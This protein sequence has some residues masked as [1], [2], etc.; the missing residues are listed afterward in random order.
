VALLQAAHEATIDG[1]LVVS[2]DG[3]VITSN[4]RFRE[5]W[6]IPDEVVARRSDEEALAS[7]LHQLEDPDGFLRRV[8]ELYTARAAGRDEVR[9]LDGRVFDRYGSP[10]LGADG[11]Y[12]GYAWY[13]R[14][15]T[16]ER[17]AAAALEVSEARYR[18]LV[19][20]LSNEV[21][22]ASADGRLVADM[23]AW[24]A[25][26]GQSEAQLLDGGWLDGVHPADRAGARAAWEA[27]LASGSTYHTEYRIQPVAGS[28]AE[29]AAGTRTIEVRGVPLVHAD[30]VREWVGGL[31][32]RDGPPRSGG[33]ARA[34]RRGG[35]RGGGAH[36][37]PSAGD[38]RARGRRHRCRRHGRDHGT[39]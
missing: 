26:T 16:G 6:Q 4:A 35:G 21:W 25:V 2:P 5:M 23:P 20:A 8:N 18:S 15:V 28:A 11:T 17:D 39:G 14:D 22:Y 13:V 19:S 38:R 27:S 32:R 33:R 30:G 24:R 12:V 7:V 36:P 1:V 37:R 29:R 10:L 34:V 31:R 9:L 3:R